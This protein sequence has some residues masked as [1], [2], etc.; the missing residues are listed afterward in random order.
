MGWVYRAEHVKLGREVALKLLKPQYAAR[1][2][3]VARFFQEA[4]AVNRI[5]HRNIVDVTDFVELEDGTVFIIMELLRGA[6]LS[7]LARDGALS[8]PRLLAILVQIADALGAAHDVGIVHRDMKP[9]NIFVSQPGDGGDHV[10]LLDFGVA[11]LIAA[12]AESAWETKAGSVIGTPAYM[13]PE[14]AGGLQVDGRS[15]LYSV[16]AIMYEMFCGQPLFQARSFGEYVRMHLNEQPLPPRATAGGAALDERIER[17]ILRCIEKSPDARYPHLRAL[18]DDLMRLLGAIETGVLA[19]PPATPMLPA[20]R[21]VSHSLPHVPTTSPVP[22]VP[23]ERSRAPWFAAGAIALG[24]AAGVAFFLAA[25]GDSPSDATTRAAPP[26]P[27]PAPRPVVSPIDP[28]PVTAPRPS[29]LITV[30]FT[31]DP[32]GAELAVEGGATR[33]RT[34]CDL[35]IDPGDGGS[36]TRRRFVLSRPGYRPA[37]VTIALAQPPERRHVSLRRAASAAEERL[38]EP[39]EAPDD[40]GREPTDRTRPAERR[41]GPPDAPPDTIDPEDTLDPFEKR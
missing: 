10:K 41:D 22:R 35:S 16:G 36:L 15:D 17:V 37:A 5:R 7:A 23:V 25:R 3:S 21:S 19:R 6:P 2:D 28:A 32:S 39:D 31:S 4:R 1:R 26:A 8:A 33:C 20:P 9:D 34:P 14:Q 13:S 18:R 27:A 38:A 24:A 12:D 40:G 30:R 29:A 11:K